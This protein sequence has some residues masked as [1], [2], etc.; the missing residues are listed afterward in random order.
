MRLRVHVITRPL[1]LGAPLARRHYGEQRRQPRPDTDH[2]NAVACTLRCG[3]RSKK[4]GS[5]GRKESACAG[6][7]AGQDKAEIV[8]VRRAFIVTVSP[9][10]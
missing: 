2:W 5:E 7:S 4:S 3:R 1:L 8:E 6:G 10:K 9:F